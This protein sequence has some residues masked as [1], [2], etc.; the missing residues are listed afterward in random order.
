M[1]IR[2]RVEEAKNIIVCRLS[3]E[4]NSSYAPGT[5]QTGP[6]RSHADDETPQRFAWFLWLAVAGF[7]NFAGKQQ[8][9]PSQRNYRLQFRI[10]VI[11]IQFSSGGIAD[12]FCSKDG[13]GLRVAFCLC[14]QTSLRAKPFIWKWVLPT[15][16][17]YAN[18]THF[19]YKR[20]AS[21][22]V[23]KQRHKITR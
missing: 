10:Q 5:W 12:L 6:K 19:H 17:F 21:G 3:K 15:G 7:W 13:I 14:V 9:I 22:L 18:Q 1:Y 8:P 4:L 23:L 2:R 11:S 16:S 20:F